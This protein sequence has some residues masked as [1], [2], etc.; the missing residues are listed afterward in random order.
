MTLG[1]L[2]ILFYFILFLFYWE[3]GDKMLVDW[4]GYKER[5]MIISMSE[6]RRRRRRSKVKCYSGLL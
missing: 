3:N 5:R 2:F 6:G 1:G 4:D